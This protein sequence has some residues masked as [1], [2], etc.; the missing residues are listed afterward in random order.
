M[1]HVGSVGTLTAPSRMHCAFCA[2]LGGLGY[3]VVL[4]GRIVGALTCSVF[5]LLVVLIH[6]D[7]SV[8]C[9]SVKSGPCLSCIA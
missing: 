3:S 5:E 6:D 1:Q 9:S 4:S 8:F 2:D 7:T